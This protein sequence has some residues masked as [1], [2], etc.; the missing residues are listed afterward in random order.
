MKKSILSKTRKTLKKR[1]P[2]NI[3]LLFNNKE[4][5][6]NLSKSEEFIKI[7]MKETL[8]SLTDAIKSKKETAEIVNIINLD[9]TV[10]IKQK[11]F[12][13]MLDNLI[14]YY[15]EKEEYEVCVSINKLKKKYEKI[16]SINK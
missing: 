15:E 12:K 7:V 6:L 8:A 4:D 14:K 9:C 13:D 16:Q 11:D 2:H 1:E 5:L 3:E 10:T